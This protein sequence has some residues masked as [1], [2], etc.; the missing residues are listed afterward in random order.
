MTPSRTSFWLPA[1][2]ALGAVVA[3]FAVTG[4]TAPTRANPAP[5]SASP[6]DYAKDVQPIFAKHCYQCHGPEKQKG[7]F[8]ADSKTL[9]FHAADSGEKPIVADDVS[10]SHL[11]ALVRGD[12]PDEVM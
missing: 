4:A 10:K 3:V 11:L 8:R 9:A 1:G 12:K 5:A 6:V 2:L 7:G